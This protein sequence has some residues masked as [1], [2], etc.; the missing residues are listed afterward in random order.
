MCS[1]LILPTVYG[2]RLIQSTSYFFKLRI[3]PSYHCVV[4]S[5]K[6]K[7]SSQITERYLFSLR[8]TS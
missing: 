6:V 4:C 1:K 7:L 2:A 8:L 5:A 3:K